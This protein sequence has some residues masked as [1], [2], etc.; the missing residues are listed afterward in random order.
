[1]LYQDCSRQ[2]NAATPAERPLLLLDWY[3][4]QQLSLA[5]CLRLLGDWWGH[6]YSSWDRLRPLLLKARELP[7]QDLA[8]LLMSTS[9]KE[10]HRKLPARLHVRFEPRHEGDEWAGLAPFSTKQELN[11]FCASA[12]ARR[13]K[14]RA[15]FVLTDRRHCILK[16]DRKGV[17][18]LF[19]LPGL[20]QRLDEPV[21]PQFPMGQV[22]REEAQ[23]TL[24]PLSPKAR[25]VKL[26]ALMP[27]IELDEWLELVA[28][29]W[30][31]LQD[32]T[33][34]LQL[35]VTTLSSAMWQQRL[36]LNDGSATDLDCMAASSNAE[37]YFCAMDE[38]CRRFFE[39]V[40]SRAVH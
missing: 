23:A 11:A 25:C 18:V 14:A 5:D 28:E 26:I 17:I 27:M 35:M 16:I 37:I 2:L 10:E 21:Q 38:D 15:G 29:W 36:V 1:M 12:G 7:A 3:E 40:R 20:L 22:T 6:L 8:A 34:H 19:N 4:R 30:E 31:E 9:E 24:A 13:S 32:P 39:S 33:G